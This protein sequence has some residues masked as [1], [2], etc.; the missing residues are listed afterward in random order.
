MEEAANIELTVIGHVTTMR[1]TAML[2]P[3]VRF[4][5][6]IASTGNGLLVTYVEPDGAG[7]E[8]RVEV[9]D[10]LNKQDG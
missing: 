7:A 2:H 3:D 8:Q 10:F 9:G 1:F 6:T 5:V 4:G